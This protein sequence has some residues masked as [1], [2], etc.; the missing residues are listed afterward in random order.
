MHL[1]QAELD[2]IAVHWNLHSIRK[3]RNSEVP[4]GKPDY[5]YFVPELFGGHNY[6]KI[7]DQNDVGACC[8]MY[9]LRRTTCIKEFSKMDVQEALEL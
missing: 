5:M 1:I 8:E 2:R 9:S 4:N 6:G 3:Q 7:V